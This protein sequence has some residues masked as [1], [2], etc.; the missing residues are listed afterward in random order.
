MHEM[1]QIAIGA[2]VFAGE[3]I[4]QVYQNNNFEVTLKADDSPLTLADR[5]AHD[6]IITILNDTG[7]PVLSE[8]GRSIPY[9]QRSAWSRFWLV[10]PLDGTKEF[11]K[12]NNEFT[13]NI[14]LI[15]NQRP[16]LGVV[17]VP[18]TRVLYAGIV[19]DSAFKATVADDVFSQG[20]VLVNKTDLPCSETQT[21]TVVASRSH[22]SAETDKLIDDL[23]RAKGEVEL[24]SVGSSLK[25]CLVA[26]GK[27]DVY[28][29]LAPTMEWDIA[30]GQAV[31]EAS[32]CTIIDF[33]TRKALVYNK[34]ELLNP[35]FVVERG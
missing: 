25:I 6:Q 10:D 12:R 15:E 1:L 16:V 29:R 34:P 27:A 26:E 33:N 3:K 30:A 13:V 32:G 4:M 5:A 23:R 14:A 19:N 18:A 24:I 21:Y 7:L 20:V 31:A 17:Y 35:W 2:A 28:P 22:L 11:I 8:E 9:E